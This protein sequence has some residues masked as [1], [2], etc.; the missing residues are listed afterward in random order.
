MD[1]SYIET[2][3]LSDESGTITALA[4]PFATPDRVG[5]MIEKG[6]FAR[7]RCPCPCS[8]AMIRMTR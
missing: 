3:I 4:W 6:A 2:K 1:R 8:S 7:A 5:D